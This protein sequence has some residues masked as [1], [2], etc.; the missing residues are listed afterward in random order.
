MDGWSG[1]VLAGVT[2]GIASNRCLMSF[3]AF[4]AKL[5]CF[6]VLLGVVPGATSIVEEEGHEDSSAGRE[7]QE[8]SEGFSTEERSSFVGSNDSKDDSNGDW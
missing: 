5:A 4:A 8:A 6:D 3:G 2:D 7:H 1:C